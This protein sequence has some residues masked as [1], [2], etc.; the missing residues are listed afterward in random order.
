M[1][2]ARFP[3]VEANPDSQN[4]VPAV[5]RI[6]CNIVLGQSG[7]LTYL[8]VGSSYDIQLCSETLVSDMCQVS[9][10]LVPRFGRSV[11]LCLGTRGRLHSCQM[12]M[13][14]L[15]SPNLSVV[16]AKC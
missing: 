2:D 4:S 12:V 1:P 11:L 15:A 10:L 6:L 14:N 7:M 9:E 13:E 16:V 5:C 8:F 3:D